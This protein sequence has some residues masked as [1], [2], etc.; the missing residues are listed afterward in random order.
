MYHEYGFSD[1]EALIDSLKSILGEELK[2]SF[3]YVI[4]NIQAF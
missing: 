1:A 3:I 4:N 2:V